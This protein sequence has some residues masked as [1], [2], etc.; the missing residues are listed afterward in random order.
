M[1][2]DHGRRRARTDGA[3]A[4]RGRDGPPRPRPRARPPRVL[5]RGRAAGRRRVGRGVRGGG[6]GLRLDAGADD[7]AVRQRRARRRQAADAPGVRGVAAARLGRRAAP[8]RRRQRVLRDVP[9]RPADGVHVRLLHVPRRQPRPRPAQQ[10]RPR[11]RQ[12]RRAPRRARAGRRVRVG[13]RGRL[14]RGAHRG[15]RD[16]HHRR[17]GAAR[18]HP[19]EPSARARRGR[20]VPPHGD[21]RAA[22]RRRV[23]PRVLDRH[24]RARALPQLRH[25]LR[26]R[27]RRAAARRALPAAHHHDQPR[28]HQLQLGLDSTLRA[29]EY[30]FASC[31][32]AFQNNQRMLRA[33]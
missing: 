31:E 10:G 29:Y 25:F 23:R 19:A 32:G 12:A 24:V 15:A 13:A 14:R 18:V 28:R 4:A 11:H 8:L 27:G 30:Y 20:R 33:T 22:R 21:G 17:S 7:R 9:D 26:Q 16:G 3:G 2:Q 5:R 6:V 1:G